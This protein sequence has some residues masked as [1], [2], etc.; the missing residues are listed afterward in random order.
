[1]EE[2]SALPIKFVAEQV[3]TPPPSSP[4]PGSSSVDEFTPIAV[5]GITPSS[6]LHW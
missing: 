4:I 1:M 2:D 6:F 5:E 3:Y